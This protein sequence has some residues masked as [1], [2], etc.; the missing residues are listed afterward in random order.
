MSTLDLSLDTLDLHLA[1]IE[2]ADLNSL[3]TS[4]FAPTE[5]PAWTKVDLPTNTSKIVEAE[6]IFL[7]D[8]KWDGLEHLLNAKPV[9]HDSSNTRVSVFDRFDL[10]KIT[11]DELSLFGEGANNRF[12]FYVG[13]VSPPKG[14]FSKNLLTVS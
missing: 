5:L 4:I 10:G 12:S 8:F 2:S 1:S 6:P 11:D 13:K 14:M 3:P 9:V 7:D